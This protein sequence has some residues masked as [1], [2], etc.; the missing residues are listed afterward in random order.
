MNQALESLR[1]QHAQIEAA[2]EA[3]VLAEGMHAVVS[4]EGFLNGEPLEGANKSGHLHQVGSN[5]PILG[6][7]VDKDLMGKR[8]GEQVEIPQTYPSQHPDEKLAG[9]NG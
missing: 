1:N 5:A 4:I 7:E 8:A 6:V 9:E 2:P 3:A